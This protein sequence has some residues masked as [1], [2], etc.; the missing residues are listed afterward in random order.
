VSPKK[1]YQKRLPT[2]LPPTPPRPRAPAPTTATAPAEPDPDDQDPF[3]P[4]PDD[5]DLFEPDPGEPAAPQTRLAPVRR[6]RPVVPRPA[7]IAAVCLVLLLSGVLVV[8]L[9][10]DALEEQPVAGGATSSEEAGAPRVLAPG[11]S[12]VESEV[13]ADG[14]VL[15]HQWINTDRPLQEIRLVLPDVSS[16][17]PLSALDIR[18][19]ASGTA[20][21]G[22][23]RIER[24][25]AAFTFFPTTDIEIQYRLRGAVDPSASAPGRA[26]AVATTLDVDYAPR[27][28]SETRVVRSAGVVLTLAC[29]SSPQE[30][31]SPCGVADG[32]QWEVEL[33]G[34]RVADRVV[35]Q[36]DVPELT[37]G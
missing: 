36:V 29:A 1:Q 6:P 5:Q 25:G 4:D 22:P 31:P 27:A 2:V 28:G 17:E 33:D 16:P 10:A 14:D 30:P 24:R 12:Y 20:A 9:V 8:R 26:L 3:E 11:E 21:D 19:S 37:S 32:G 13:L 34:D 35:A 15:V 18:V 7:L 23:S